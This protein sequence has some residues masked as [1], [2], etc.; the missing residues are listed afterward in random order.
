MAKEQTAKEVDM[1]A[2]GRCIDVGHDFRIVEGAAC[3]EVW[4][5]L[6]CRCCDYKTTSKHLES[7][8]DLAVYKEFLRVLGIGS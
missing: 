4:F 6:E 2:M 8:E 7:E 5:D 3:R 1:Q